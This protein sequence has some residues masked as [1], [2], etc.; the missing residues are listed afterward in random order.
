M[1]VLL[2]SAACL[3]PA[4]CLQFSAFGIPD[5]QG[6]SFKYDSQGK[7]PRLGELL[8]KKEKKI[9]IR[10]KCRCAATKENY[11]A[12]SVTSQLKKNLPC[13]GTQSGNKIEHLGVWLLGYSNTAAV[14]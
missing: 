14:L 4:F 1:T 8:R 2:L 7:P 3:I 12:F 13:S 5:H 10:I 6:A 11:A 9:D